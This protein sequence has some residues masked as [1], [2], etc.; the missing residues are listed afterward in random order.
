MEKTYSQCV[1]RRQ[2]TQASGSLEFTPAIVMNTSYDRQRILWDDCIF[3]IIYLHENHKKPTMD[4]VGYIHHIWIHRWYEW[5]S[6]SRFSLSI[7]KSFRAP[8]NCL[9]AAEEKA[10]NPLPVASKSGHTSGWIVVNCSNISIFQWINIREFHVQNVVPF[11]GVTC[12]VTFLAI[13]DGT[14]HD[15]VTWYCERLVSGPEHIVWAS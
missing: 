15:I 14:K 13:I 8:P 6:S 7:Q 1:A 2:K 11:G 4:H 10:G 9:Y 5:C 3:T 12:W